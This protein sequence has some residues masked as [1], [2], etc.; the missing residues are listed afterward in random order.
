MGRKRRFPAVCSGGEAGIGA[1]E[2]W[3]LCSDMR[4][5][6]LPG[7]GSG[8]D[9]QGGRPAGAVGEDAQPHLVFPLHVVDLDLQA[10]IDEL[11]GKDFVA[12][13]RVEATGV[14]ELHQ[15]PTGDGQPVRAGPFEDEV[16]R[17]TLEGRRDAVEAEQ[18]LEHAVTAATVTEAGG[19]DGGGVETGGREDRREI[20]GLENHTSVHDGPPAARR[21]LG[22]GA[23]GRDQVREGLPV[24][25][26]K[27]LEPEGGADPG[28]LS[29]LPC[30][31]VV[32]AQLVSRKTAALRT[33]Y[34]ELDITCLIPRSP[35][36][37]LVRRSCMHGASL[38]V[39]AGCGA[40]ESEPLSHRERQGG[41]AG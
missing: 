3:L 37:R 14:V 39:C 8:R 35:L 6:L 25:R 22:V 13:L 20:L 4:S 5:A 18:E 21:L 26:E 17:D 7:G 29:D 15:A 41:M 36:S 2:F 12:L 30:L 24:E 9:I 34:V 40:Q 19:G 27:G 10:G 1:E 32:H 28:C 16:V 11:S 38:P 23:G 33:R 31:I